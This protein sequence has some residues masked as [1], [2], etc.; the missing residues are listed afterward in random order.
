MSDYDAV[1]LSPMAEAPPSFHTTVFPVEDQTILL[2]AEKL[3]AQ[4]RAKHYYT[5]TATFDLRC[6]RCGVGLVGEK[7]AREH[8][9]QTGREWKGSTRADVRC[10][11]WRVLGKLG[12]PGSIGRLEV[13]MP[14]HMSSLI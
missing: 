3:I 8:A 9:M 14:L 12:R 5:D 2:T 6:G 11:L 7:G 13:L 1:S 4:L 10:R